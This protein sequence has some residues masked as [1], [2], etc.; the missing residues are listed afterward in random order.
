MSHDV[1]EVEEGQAEPNQ[2][3]RVAEELQ[4]LEEEAAEPDG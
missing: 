1:T 3:W 4:K 2:R